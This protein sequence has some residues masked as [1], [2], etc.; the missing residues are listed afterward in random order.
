MHRTYNKKYRV[1]TTRHPAWDYGW[2]AKYFVTICTAKHK[3]FLGNIKD[4]T[5][6]LS[7]IGKIGSK[8][9]TEIPKHFSFVVLDGFV[10]MPN[11]I[12]GIIII[13]KPVEAQNLAPPKSTP[14]RAKEAQNIASVPGSEAQNIA[15]VPGSEAQN[16]ASV[17]GSE[18]QN[19]APLQ[20]QRFMYLPDYKTHNNFSSQSQNLP[21]IIRGYKAAVKKYATI[22]KIDFEW[23]KLYFDRII[24][25]NN[26][27]DRIKEYIVSNPKNWAENKFNEPLFERQESNEK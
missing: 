6:H 1:D 19:I 9:W 11:H 16:I 20:Q 22:N 18:A 15:S 7:E 17:P 3:H 8:F 26:E 13:D 24:R 14:Y 21:A 2:N 12:H 4:E 25:D 23:Q 27:M 10:V 5:V